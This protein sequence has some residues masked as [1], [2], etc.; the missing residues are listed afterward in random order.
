VT[1]QI[2]NERTHQSFEDAAK[3]APAV[4]HTNFHATRDAWE[5]RHVLRLA[6]S[7]LIVLSAAVLAAMFVRVDE[8]Q[9]PSG[10][11]GLGYNGLAAALIA[12]WWFTLVA[13]KTR[14]QRLFGDD[15]EEYRRVIRATVFTFSLLAIVS[16]L[17]KADLS[18]SY[19]ALAFPTG[20][21]GLLL[22]RKMWRVWLREKRYR[23]Y[24]LSRVLVIGGVRSGTMLAREFDANKA[25]GF[26]VVGVWEPD[27]K[28]EMAEWLEIDHRFA[29]VIGTERSLS[30]ALEITNANTVIV[31]DTE[32]LGHEGLRDLMWK[33]EDAGVDLM[34]APNMVD[35]AGARLHMREI[36]GMAFLHLE[37]P[38][39]GAAGQWPKALFDRLGAAFLV[40]ALSPLMLITALAIKLTSKGPVF[41]LQERIG[42]EGAPFRMIKFRS[43]RTGADAELMALLH[44]QGT[45]DQPLFKVEND[46]RIT[47]VGHF[48]RRFSIDEL[49]QLF[50]V[51]KGDMSLVGPRP[52]QAAEVELYD[53]AAHR[54]LHVRPGMTGLWQ[55]SG[56][57]DLTWDETIRLDTSYVENWSMTADLL[58][59]WRT[60]RA[61]LGSDGAY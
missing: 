29:P 33:L 60:V 61:V 37:E 8:P 26:R 6:I 50:N 43:M 19:L 13:Y 14:D 44:A 52:Q 11:F 38:R 51:L 20:M 41:Y 3:V 21:L 59:L 2:G 31:T 54:R 15:S 7:D 48:I 47:K 35:V 28:H 53:E 36:S 27:R 49:P 57:S 25:A 5:K 46:P 24:G 58:I 55:V 42:R 32:H 17:V 16:L 18:R 34:V 12:V 9:V 22:S 1:Q 45:A 30:E 4:T 10:L 40:L 39:Y 56:R 23:G